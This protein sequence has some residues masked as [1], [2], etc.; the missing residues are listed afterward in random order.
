MTKTDR[1]ADSL[2]RMRVL[3]I[4]HASLTPALRERERALVRC[5][6]NV[7]LEV[8]TTR[9][10]R[11]AELDVEAIEDDLFPVR[12]SRAWLS[13]HIQLF[14]YDPRP[15]VASLRRHRPHLVEVNHEPYSIACAEVLTLC[16]WFA[17]KATVVMQVCQNIY[18]RYPPP[19]N[20]LER[21]ALKRVD[22][23]S[24]CSD[25]VRELLDAKGF[26]KPVAIVPF[27]VNTTAFC[28]RDDRPQ[29]T[30]PPTIGFVGRM[31]HGKGLK[32]L[33]EALA[34]LGSQP[35]RLMVV[36]DGPTREP[37]QQELAAHG[38]IDRTEF[39][40]AVSYDQMPEFY[41]RM[42]VVAVPSRT[43][44]RVRE[45][46]GR[47]LVE[48][49]ASGVP[50][51]GSTSGA[52]PEVIADAGLVVPEG[53]AQALANAMRRMLSDSA[54]R[55]RLKRAGRERAV[56]NFSWERVAERTYELFSEVLR[57]RSDALSETEQA[58]ALTEK[59]AHQVLE[60]F[61]TLKVE[62]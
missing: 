60:S 31:L 25:T 37:F 45:Q 12:R 9:R 54:L 32:V 22:A 52:I 7:E 4:S 61:G 38:L 49:M 56:E 11:E 36:G 13:K 17:P 27:G 43:T 6:P 53:D 8:V 16:D 29:R 30:G 55:S 23:A 14:A 19:F 39:V 47:V 34:M 1:Q 20:W 21:R 24:A 51:I 57:R 59:G 44:K 18:R 15:I 48:A 3:R 2:D 28:P 50:V 26:K 41:Q 5:R 33:A 10:W 58:S 35:W 42:D 46:F 62:S 40:G